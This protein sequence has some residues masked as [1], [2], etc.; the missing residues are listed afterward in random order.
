MR[1]TACFLM[2]AGFIGGAGDNA[3]AGNTTSPKPEWQIKLTIPDYPDGVG[4]RP[5]VRPAVTFVDSNKLAV[6][7]AIPAPK[8]SRS[9]WELDLLVLSAADGS[10]QGRN[11]FSMAGRNAGL[12][13][14]LEGKLVVSL[15]DGLRVLSQT[16]STER[17]RALEGGIEPYSD[18]NHVILVKS[19]AVAVKTGPQSGYV[20]GAGYNVSFVRL[21]TLE[22]Q[23]ACERAG[24]DIPAAILGDWVATSVS[25]RD[26]HRGIYLGSFCED[27]KRIS[28]LQ[29]RPDFLG[30]ETLVVTDL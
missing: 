16:L 20:R 18:G 3:R 25:S 14:S 26:A 19:Q 27:W 22:T 29:G 30:P 8:G 24:L 13:R 2:I 12:F 15:G 17:S 5:S 9:A 28:D 10:I 1:F 21:D 23:A 4:L 6:A 7:Y 11:T